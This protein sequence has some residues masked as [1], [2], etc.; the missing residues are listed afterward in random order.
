M[1]GFKQGFNVAGISGGERT[2]LGGLDLSPF[3]GREDVE[4]WLTA[5]GGGKGISD[6]SGGIGNVST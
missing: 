1:P 4:C 5:G 3:G 6:V 2:G